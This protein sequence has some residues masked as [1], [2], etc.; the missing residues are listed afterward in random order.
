MATIVEFRQF[1]LESLG[2]LLLADIIRTYPVFLFWLI[3]NFISF[4]NDAFWLKSHIQ[5]IFKG[6]YLH[7]FSNKQVD[8]IFYHK[9][10]NI[11]TR[12][13]TQCINLMSDF[14][15]IYIKRQ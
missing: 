14:K 8:A 15:V 11:T 10:K 1:V 12:A 5:S 7:F 13:T 6:L 3:I 9:I 4:W 2:T